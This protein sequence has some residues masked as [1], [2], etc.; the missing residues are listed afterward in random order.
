MPQINAAC[1]PHS[2]SGDAV[3]GIRAASFS[4]PA[5]CGPG[6]RRWQGWNLAAEV[7]LTNYAPIRRAI[8]EAKNN[9]RTDL[10]LVERCRLLRG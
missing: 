6:H 3:G 1:G 10:V 8:P 5:S 2:L 7:A 4:D 9:L